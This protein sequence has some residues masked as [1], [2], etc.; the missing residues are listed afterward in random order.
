[1]YPFIPVTQL[2]RWHRNLDIVRIS[3]GFTWMTWPGLTWPDL[4]WL[5]YAFVASWLCPGLVTSSSTGQS[6]T[7]QR[8]AWLMHQVVEEKRMITQFVRTRT[9]CLGVL[10][11]LHHYCFSLAMLFSWWDITGLTF[12]HLS[13]QI[14]EK[15]KG[16]GFQLRIS[17]ENWSTFPKD[18]TRFK[19][20]R[21]L[22]SQNKRAKMKLGH[23]P[24]PLHQD[25]RKAEA[26]EQLSK[27]STSSGSSTLKCG[28]NQAANSSSGGFYDRLVSSILFCLFIF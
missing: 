16:S 17:K 24:E 23:Q 21:G 10:V 9:S 5:D 22:H 26:E 8:G 3:L 6:Q 27:R 25:D 14:V 12:E 15:N 11:N 28:Y 1:M 13:E 2:M 18:K 20:S 4:A 7:D 19:E